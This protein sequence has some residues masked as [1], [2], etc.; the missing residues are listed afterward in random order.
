[1]F[2]FSQVS[3]LNLM[4]MADIAVTRCDPDVRVPKGFC[5]LTYSPCQGFPTRMVYLRQDIL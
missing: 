1:M 5:A 3:V 2:E 4:M